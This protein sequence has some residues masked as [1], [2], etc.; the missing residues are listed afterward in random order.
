MKPL[1][2]TTIIVWTDYDPNRQD[3]D[4]CDLTAEA[5]SGDAYCSKQDT[6]RVENPADDTDWDGT[7]FFYKH[8]DAEDE[9]DEDDYEEVSD[10]NS[11]D[12]DDEDERDNDE[13]E[14]LIGASDDEID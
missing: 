1:Y 4:I 6:K 13:V 11:E 10:N 8:G 2:K 12:E 7:E 14:D 5:K 9:N 3:L